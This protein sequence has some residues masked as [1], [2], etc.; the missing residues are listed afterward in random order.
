[1]VFFYYEFK[2]NTF[3][4][5]STVAQS[6]HPKKGAANSHL[7]RG[8][9]YK[10]PPPIHCGFV[11]VFFQENEAKSTMEGG[12]SLVRGRFVNRPLLGTMGWGD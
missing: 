2:H 6:H 3:E 11:C 12:S 7:A 5:T 9:V 8:P 1:M 10:L 4:L